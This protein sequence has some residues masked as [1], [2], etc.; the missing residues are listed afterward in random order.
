MAARKACPICDKPASA[1]HTPFCSARCKDVDLNR[2]LQGG[3]VIAGRPDDEA[4]SAAAGRDE[5]LSSDDEG[6][7]P[8]LRH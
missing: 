4:A 7:S 1:H 6:S 3:Y 2:W 8:R 5:P